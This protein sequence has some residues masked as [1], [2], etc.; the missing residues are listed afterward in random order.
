MGPTHIAGKKTTTK[1]TNKETNAK[2][3]KKNLLSF[4]E[5]RTKEERKKNKNAKTPVTFVKKARDAKS[6]DNTK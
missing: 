5:K 4:L 1:S 3:H 6:A 2:S